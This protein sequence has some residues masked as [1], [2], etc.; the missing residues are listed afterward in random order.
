MSG[1]LIQ[2]PAVT[3]VWVEVPL[4][5]GDAVVVKRIRCYA[6]GAK[7]LAV[8]A[9]KAVSTIDADTGSD[10]D[11]G[12]A[13]EHPLEAAPVFVSRAHD[14]AARCGP[15]GS[16]IAY[17]LRTRQPDDKGYRRQRDRFRMRRR[18]QLMMGWFG[19]HIALSE[20]ERWNL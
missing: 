5:R 12:G 2:S 1:H 16:R 18:Q 11:A 20:W 4:R 15:W 14:L 10:G 19:P 17:G 9:E 7:A 13:D 6:V 8:N 3:S